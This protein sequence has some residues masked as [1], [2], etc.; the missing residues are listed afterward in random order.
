MRRKTKREAAISLFKKAG[1]ILSMSEALSHGIHRS[2]LYAL[3]DEGALEV[4]GRGIYRLKTEETPFSDF[5]MVSKKIPKAVICLTSALSFHGIT[6]QIPQQIHIAIPPKSHKPLIAY[7]PLRCFWYSKHLLETGIIGH[8]MNGYSVKIFDM[9]KT[10]IDCLK[11]RNK[12]GID[13]VLE[14][15]KMYW[16]RKDA[17]LKKL[18]NYA[19]LFHMENIL[20][21]IIEVITNR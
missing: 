19:A 20:K 8:K 9:E 18:L 3:R 14:A 10:L 7:P 2:V 15:L 5:I 4:L 6:T 16:Q 11:F 13:I 21:P 12:I 17:N 1:G